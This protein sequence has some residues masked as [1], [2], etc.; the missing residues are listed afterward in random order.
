MPASIL[1]SVPSSASRLDPRDPDR[2]LTLLE[3][4]HLVGGA[5]ATIYRLMARD[6]TFPR[7]A[8]LGS[9][10]RWSAKEIAAWMEAQLAARAARVR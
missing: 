10:N 4:R 7:P 9:A 6:P 8:K 5:T 3:V 2:W 1:A